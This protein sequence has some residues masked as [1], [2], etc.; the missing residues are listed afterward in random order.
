MS[1]APSKMP[2]ESVKNNENVIENV[3]RALNMSN[4]RLADELGV[5][6]ATVENWKYHNTPP[7]VD[8]LRAI[9]GLLVDKIHALARI[10]DIAT[11][12]ANARQQKQEPQAVKPTKAN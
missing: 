1:K 12:A 7:S 9:I 11:R 2:S 5:T 8:C 10:Q 6:R 4:Q 3:T